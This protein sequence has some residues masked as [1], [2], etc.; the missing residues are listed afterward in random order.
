MLPFAP[1]SADF[2]VAEIESDGDY[3]GVVDSLHQLNDGQQHAIITTF[4]GLHVRLP[5]G[6]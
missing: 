3:D 1:P 5:S 2:V 4:V 6:N